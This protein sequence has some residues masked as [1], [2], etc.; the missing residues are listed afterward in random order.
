MEYRGPTVSVTAYNEKENDRSLIQGTVPT[1]SIWVCGRFY[2]AMVL[3][4]RRTEEQSH[5]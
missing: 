1:V 4:S 5:L 3:L 2:V